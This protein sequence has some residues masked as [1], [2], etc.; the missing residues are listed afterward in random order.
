MVMMLQLLLLL[1]RPGPSSRQITAMLGMFQTFSCPPSASW[2]VCE[3]LCFFWLMRNFQA[4]S[5]GLGRHNSLGHCRRRNVQ[6]CCRQ[7]REA[8]K[9]GKVPQALHNVHHG[10]Q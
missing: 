7:I 2:A 9:R 6:R 5:S 8:K 3:R 4:L 1:P 10:V